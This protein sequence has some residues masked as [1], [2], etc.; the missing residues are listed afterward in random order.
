[1]YRRRRSL[2]VVGWSM[3]AAV[4]APLVDTSA[5]LS[6]LRRVRQTGRTL[7]VQKPS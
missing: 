3:N 7:R 1:M 4:S 5:L 6:S 2:M